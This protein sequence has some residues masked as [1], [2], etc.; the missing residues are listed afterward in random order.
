M[1]QDENEDVAASVFSLNDKLPVKFGERDSS[2][3]R[4]EGV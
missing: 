3:A 1:V 4:A 2:E